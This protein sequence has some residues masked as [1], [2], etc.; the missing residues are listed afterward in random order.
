MPDIETSTMRDST[1]GAELKKS[2]LGD[3]FITQIYLLL[4]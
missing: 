2:P 4:T 3:F 1:S